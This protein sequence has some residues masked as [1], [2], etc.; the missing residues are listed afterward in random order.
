[1]LLSQVLV[2]ALP[3]LLML[4]LLVPPVPLVLWIMIRRAT[5]KSPA[6]RRPHIVFV[7][8]HDTNSFLQMTTAILPP[9]LLLQALQ[10]VARPQLPQSVCLLY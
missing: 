8:N 3:V 5:V 9:F 6:V 1:M 7:K 4:L 10:S 2:L